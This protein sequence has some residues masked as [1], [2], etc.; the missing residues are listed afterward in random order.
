MRHTRAMSAALVD[1]GSRCMTA[2]QGNADEEPREPLN[3][4]S[5]IACL[6]ISS[7]CGLCR[8]IHAQPNRC[9]QDVFKNEAV[10]YESPGAMSN[11]GR[12]LFSCVTGLSPTLIAYDTHILQMM[13][14]MSGINRDII[15]HIQARSERRRAFPLDQSMETSR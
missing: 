10:Q 6:P 3:S 2:H 8:P 5:Y 4:T 13:I 12:D 15:E 7:V 11:P 1:L 14:C 9:G